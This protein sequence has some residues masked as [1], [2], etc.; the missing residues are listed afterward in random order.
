VSGIVLTI[1]C[2]HAPTPEPPAG[3]PASG[4]LLRGFDIVAGYQ[5]SWLLM[6]ADYPRY[7]RS[8]RAAA[9]ATFL[10]LALTA[11]WFMPLGFL[12]ASVAHSSDPGAMISALGLG[13]WGGLLVTLATLT[14]N[15]VN[16][17]MS[18]LAFKSL[19]P[20]ISDRA[21]IWII[22]GV[23][24][25]L[26]VLSQTWI[27]QF[28]SFTLLIAGSFVPVGG[29]L[30]AH[31]VIARIPV[32]VPDLYDAAGPYARLAGWLPGLA[33]WALGALTFYLAAPIGGTLPSLA[34]SIAAYATL[35][36]LAS[37]SRK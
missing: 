19:R 33:A 29:M 4:D 14:T 9:V 3:R 18:A 25:A 12:A 7:V 30:I 15:F 32:H 36:H 8:G 23:G 21:N 35:T 24:A 28:A 6:F 16:I 1:A 37:R 10:G 5:V 34:V 22:G 27:D 31:Y 20:A 26:G 13:W 11:L 17:Y 2:L